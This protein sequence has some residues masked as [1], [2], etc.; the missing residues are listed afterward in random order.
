MKYAR[1]FICLVIITLCFSCSTSEKKY[2]VGVSQC[3]EDIWRDK[4]NEELRMGTFLYENVELKFASANDNDQRQRQ[5]LEA[6][7]NDG[8]DLLIVSPNQ[9]NTITETV[10]KAYNKG[11]PVILFDRKTD[12]DKYTAF[13]GADNYAIGRTMANFIVKQL[14]GHGNV[15]EIMG[16][17]GSSPAIERHRGF[18]DEMKEHPG[19]ILVGEEYTDWTEESGSEAMERVLER[20]DKIDFIFA[21]N[22]RIAEGARTVAISHGVNDIHYVGIDALSVSGGGMERVR[23]G[24]LEASYIYPTRGD[25]VIQLCMNILEGKPYQ[26]ENYLQTAIV[27]KDNA[28]SMLMQADEMRQQRYRLKELH[29]QVDHY[30]AQ[31]NHQKIYLLLSSII[32][33]LIVGIFAYI[34]R[35]IIAKRRMAEE[36]VNAKLRFF[37]NIS[38]EFRTPLTLIADPIDHL[39]ADNTLSANHRKFLLLVRKNI[40]VML[41]LV[42]QILDLRKIQNGKMNVVVKEVDIAVQIK[43]WV[44]TFVPLAAKKRISLNVDVPDSLIVTTDCGFVERI[45]YNLLANALKYTPEDGNVCVKLKTGDETFTLIVEDNGIGIPSNKLPH[46][47]D[48]FYQVEGNVGGTGIGLSLVKSLSE[49]LGGDVSAISQEGKGSTF[50]VELPMISEGVEGDKSSQSTISQDM[51]NDDAIPAT[52][53]KIDR[54]TDTEIS[55]DRPQVLVVDDNDDIRNYI[56]ALLGQNYDVFTASDGKKGLDEAIKRVPDLII[57]DVMMP[58]MD[59]F[60]VCRRIKSETATSHIPILMLTARV[61]DDQRADGY[62]CGADAY[63]TK[64]F[65]SKVLVS[66]VK[67]LLSSRQ[68]LKDLFSHSEGES[69]EEVKTTDADDKFISLFRAKVQ[70][71]LSDSSFSVETLGEEMNLSRVQLYRKVKALTGTTPVELIRIARLKRADRLIKDG[72]KTVSEVAYD[73]GFST[74]SYFIKCYKEYFGHTPSVKE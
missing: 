68:L 44:D 70:E 23:D 69:S 63:I 37:T 3:S 4:L 51:I 15:A 65:S 35:T 52:T 58:E 59:G 31:Y 36:A 16:L 64:P 8:V 42:S 13:I 39:L 11:I 66:R 46:I 71:H 10:D 38:H 73:V 50:N 19:I 30:F 72:G 41:R 34:Y 62:E 6:F 43:E 53:N 48:R 40:R 20:T 55:E 14:G 54:I 17:K 12:S 9:L 1:I 45:C 67:N 24:I 33:V 2:V 18:I 61:L 74:P 27:T 25:L 28:E 47:F 29:E 5:Q 60:E 49:L 26:R 22:D 21:H 56:S 57:C 7:I 32:I